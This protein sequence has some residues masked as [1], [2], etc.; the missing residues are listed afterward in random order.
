MEALGTKGTVWVQKR[1]KS[2]DKN[3]N[4]ALDSTTLDKESSIPHFLNVLEKAEKTNKIQSASNQ[5]INWTYPRG[6]TL[7]ITDIEVEENG[8]MEFFYSKLPGVSI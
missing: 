3:W 5:K 2:T 6:A 7:W 8:A 1:S 4:I